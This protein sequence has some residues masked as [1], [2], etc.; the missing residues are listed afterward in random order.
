MPSLISNL[1]RYSILY[2]F[3]FSCRY[4]LCKK[5]YFYEASFGVT[6]FVVSFN[7]VKIDFDF[8]ILY[9]FLPILLHKNRNSYFHFIK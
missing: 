4:T 6:F 8:H 2:S 1:H 3:T 5:T 7:S 9:I